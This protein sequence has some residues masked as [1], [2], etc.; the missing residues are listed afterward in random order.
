MIPGA[1]RTEGAGAFPAREGELP[2]REGSQTLECLSDK[3]IR[4]ASRSG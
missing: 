2:A 4:N 1:K 3:L